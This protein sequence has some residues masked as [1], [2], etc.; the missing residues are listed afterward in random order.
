MWM[1]SHHTKSLDTLHKRY[2]LFFSLN[3]IYLTFD[4]HC[5]LCGTMFRTKQDWELKSRR[6]SGPP[7]FDLRESI[8]SILYG[9]ITDLKVRQEELLCI[10]VEVNFIIIN[11]MVGSVNGGWT[12]PVF[13]LAKRAAKSGHPTK[14]FLAISVRKP[15][16]FVQDNWILTSFFFFTIA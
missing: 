1:S 8:A 5:R 13:L 15:F 9:H 10:F 4:L 14:E 11:Y 3:L 12:N 2:L 6:S 7:F 16:L